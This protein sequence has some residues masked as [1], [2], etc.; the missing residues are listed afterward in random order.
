MNE[1][2][3]REQVARARREFVRWILL[4]TMN[5]SRPTPVQLRLLVQ[6][7][8]GEYPD[9]TDLEVRRELQY[10]QER[11]LCHVVTDPLGFVSA[12][13]SRHGVDV[14]EYTVAVEPGIARPAKV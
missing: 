8:Q 3:I 7:V 5:I 6:V 14:A 12:S 2:L 13:L 11:A 10:L 1:A 4:L 9:C